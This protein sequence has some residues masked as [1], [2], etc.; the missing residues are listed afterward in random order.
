MSIRADQQAAH[1]GH[2]VSLY[3]IDATPVGGRIHRFVPGKWGGGDVV[4]GGHTYTAT[5]IEV[6]GIAYGGDGAVARP[7]L[8]LARLDEALVSA[9]LATDHWRGARFDRLRTLGQ[10]LDGEPESDPHRHWPPDVY[11]IERREKETKTE[12]V[13][14]LASPLDFDEQQL[15][16]RQVLRDL[17]GWQY[18]RW[19]ADTNRFV[20]A[21]ADVA[22]PH[23]G[24]SYFDAEDNAVSD[25]AKDTCSGRASGCLSR[26]PDRVLPFGGFIG[27]GRLRRS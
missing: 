23:T 6:E 9:I 3:T 15:P 21:H 13:F 10:Y 18:R 7:R 26:F 19:D 2:V 17:C 27:V 12:I 1:L 20:Y 11:R 16:G 22:C 25:P 4:Y 8:T 14:L 5:P 24:T